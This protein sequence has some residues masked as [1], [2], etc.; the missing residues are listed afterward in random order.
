MAEENTT[1]TT[2]T[3]E[4]ATTETKTADVEKEAFLERL[5][6]E[7][8]KRKEAE[9]RAKSLEREMAELRAQV[10]EREN[11][12]LPELE[13]ERQRAKKL[14]ER[15]AEAERRAEEADR[16]V[17]MTQRERWVTQA[18]AKLNFIDPDDAARYVDLDDIEDIDQAERAV[19]R[20]AKAKEHLL[21][22]EDPALPGRV[23]ENGRTTAATK[24]DGGINLDAEAQMVADQLKQFLK[25]RQ[26]A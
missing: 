25:D 17:Q 16:R 18:A 4:A 19:K 6:K 3:A 7:S 5:N 13:R 9:G 22:K 12:G 24:K 23:L 20:V 8:G 21:R 1:T 14:E 15:I 10:E 2:E 11:A 26:R